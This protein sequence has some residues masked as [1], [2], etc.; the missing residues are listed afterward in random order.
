MLG[1]HPSLAMDGLVA[2]G[3][4]LCIA[5]PGSGDREGHSS[6]SRAIINIGKLLA[7]LAIPVIHVAC[8]VLISL[9]S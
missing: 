5:L 8:A 7:A 1:S 9:L 4:A 6:S 2:V 3:R